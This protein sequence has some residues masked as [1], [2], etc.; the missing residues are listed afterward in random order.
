[1]SAV[2]Y[3]GREMLLR[4]VTDEN[5]YIN[6]TELSIFLHGND[7]NNDS[8]PYI[9]MASRPERYIVPVVFAFIF[10]IGVVGNGALVFFFI[11][12]PQMRNVPNTYILS[13][14]L[15]DLLVLICTVPFASIVFTLED[16]PFG[17]IVCRIQETM[18]DVSVGVTVFTLT[19]LSINRYYA[20]VKPWNKRSDGRKS[21]ITCVIIIWLV[22]F[23]LAIPAA[24]FTSLHHFEKSNSETFIN[25]FPFPEF[26]G[27]Y[28]P[29]TNVLIK[30]LI[31]YLVPLIIIGTFY[32]LMARHLIN[33]DIP[34]ECLP[35]QRNH[36]RQAASR[37]KVA[38]MVLAFVFIFAIC[39]FPNNLF[40]M[41][42]YFHPTSLDD[43]NYTWNIIRIVGFCL[44]FI[45]S[46][47]NPI[48]LYWISGTFRKYYNRH[49]FCKRGDE[50]I[51]IPSISQYHFHSSVRNFT[52][53]TTTR[54]EQFEMS[55]LNGPDK[56]HV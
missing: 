11:K 4:N 17:E 52:T 38:K 1:M 49:L 18:K 46:C 10:V 32:V 50:I 5:L 48:A 12:F 7:S 29:R 43:Y 16:F 26:L 3:G 42:F 6:G 30:F 25:C 47:I 21:T 40:L 33:Q 39:F 8:L 2:D 14:A 15:G 9:P 36:L 53:T 55:S 37:R 23:I 54:T 56:V 22:S 20:I 13:L 41:W 24:S 27:P 45:N 19:A 34:G 35:Q 31:Y 51:G 28:Y 44:T